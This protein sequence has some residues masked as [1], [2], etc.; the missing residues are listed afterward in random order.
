[1]RSKESNGRYVS[2][3]EVEVSDVAETV[4]YLAHRQGFLLRRLQV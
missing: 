1:M 2:K 3:D 4:A